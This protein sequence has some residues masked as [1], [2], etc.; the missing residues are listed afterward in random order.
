MV[1]G[2]WLVVM[3]Y[4]PSMFMVLNPNT[5]VFDLALLQESGF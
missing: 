4:I 3:V 5:L 2:W 1:G